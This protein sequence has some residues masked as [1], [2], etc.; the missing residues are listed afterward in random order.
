MDQ[1]TIDR[2]NQIAANDRRKVRT[3]REFRRGSI[4]IEFED[5]DEDLISQMQELNLRR[6]SHLIQPTNLPHHFPLDDQGQANYMD[7]TVG[8][9][10]RSDVVAVH[11]LITATSGEN[12]SEP[13]PTLPLQLSTFSSPLK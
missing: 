9:S 6:E 7:P 13:P 1:D 12:E 3:D 10:R 8:S 2:V 4:V 5:G 11:E